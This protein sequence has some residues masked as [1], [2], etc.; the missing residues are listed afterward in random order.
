MKYM[1]NIDKENKMENQNLTEEVSACF[2]KEV[3]DRNQIGKGTSFST[4]GSNQP[5]CAYCEGN[6]TRCSNYYT[7]PEINPEQS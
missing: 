4:Q 2:W 7:K 1:K 6:N 5:K 3:F